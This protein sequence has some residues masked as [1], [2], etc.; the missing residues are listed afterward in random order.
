MEIKCQQMREGGRKGWDINPP[1]SQSG[2]ARHEGKT[3]LTCFHGVPA[4]RTPSPCAVESAAAVRRRARATGTDRQ[5]I[6]RTGRNPADKG[7]TQRQWPKQTAGRGSGRGE[8]T[9]GRRR[10][11]GH[12][13]GR[14]TSQTPATGRAQPWPA[15]SATQT[16]LHEDL[17]DCEEINDSGSEQRGRAGCGRSVRTTMGGTRVSRR[18]EQRCGPRGVE[19]PPHT[20]ATM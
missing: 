17:H 4:A 1:T 14:W 2:H 8:A 7:S 20:T 12:A 3:C 15:E 5:V 13:P 11:R 18:W 10:C 16:Y 6:H 19:P 9:K